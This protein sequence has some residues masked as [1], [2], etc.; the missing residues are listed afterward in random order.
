MH[1]SK[2][3]GELQFE[4]LSNLHSCGTKMTLAEAYK[5]VNSLNRYA[6]WWVINLKG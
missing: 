1:Q 6:A 5:Q 3:I 2:T 4:H